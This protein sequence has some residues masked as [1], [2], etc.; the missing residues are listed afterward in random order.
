MS[1]CNPT[2]PNPIDDLDGDRPRRGLTLAAAP[3][4]DRR[5]FIIEVV[6]STPGGL[7]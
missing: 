3:P 1:V 4:P 2:I 6:I 7:Q 5:D